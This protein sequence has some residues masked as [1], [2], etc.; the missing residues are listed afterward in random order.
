MISSVTL[1]RS[2]RHLKRAAHPLVKPE[3]RTKLF[4]S[5]ATFAMESLPTEILLNIFKRLDAEALMQLCLVSRKMHMLGRLLL[6]RAFCGGYSS[7]ERCLARL[8]SFYQQIL[9]D[10]SLALEIRV[11]RASNIR[12]ADMDEYQDILRSL[13]ERSPNLQCLSV[14]GGQRVGGL[15]NSLL[16]DRNHFRQLHSFES[17]GPTWEKTP[18]SI[19]YTRLECWSSIFGLKGLRSLSLGGCVGGGNDTGILSDLQAS[20]ELSLCHIHI[21]DSNLGYT[22]LARLIRSCR[23]LESFCY[24]SPTGYSSEDSNPA[25]I[26]QALS[27]HE[28][29]LRSLSFDFRSRDVGEEFN[30]VPK[31]G[32]LGRFSRLKALWVNQDCLPPEP[33]LPPSLQRLGIDLNDHPLEPILFHNLAIA[34]HSTSRSFSELYVERGWGAKRPVGIFDEFHKRI[35]IVLA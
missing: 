12:P 30:Q 9:E 11:I 28:D 6:F 33:L 23:R 2:D 8:R 26:I 34:S 31:I 3:E 16:K 25:T 15:L 24:H 10:P 32:S 14:P 19:R 7:P 21:R 22:I 17:P 13:L 18:V 27:F 20:G 4:A 1:R 35:R 29:S 5:N